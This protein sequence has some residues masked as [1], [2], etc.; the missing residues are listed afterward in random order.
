MY[1]HFES[2]ITAYC[3]LLYQIRG[4]TVVCGCLSPGILLGP[5]SALLPGHGRKNVTS[6]FSGDSEEL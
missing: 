1:L 6:L 4:F 2:L 3:G 5:W